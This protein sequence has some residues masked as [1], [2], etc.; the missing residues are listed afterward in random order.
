MLSPAF[1]PDL[2]QAKSS[3]SKPTAS[4]ASPKPSWPASEM[5]VRWPKWAN[6]MLPGR[7]SSWTNAKPAGLGTEVSATPSSTPA[8]AVGA[9]NPAFATW[10][11]PTRNTNSLG[12]IATKRPAGRSRRKR[13]RM[14]QGDGKLSMYKERDGG[15]KSSLPPFYLL[16]EPQR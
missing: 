11:S 9:G 16:F 4:S 12:S 10:A 8:L 2:F 13:T 5:E 3:S 1:P 15:A 7:S 14:L 6:F